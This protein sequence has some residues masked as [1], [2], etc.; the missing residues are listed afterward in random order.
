MTSPPSA[1]GRRRP[2]SRIGRA[3]EGHP[4]VMAPHHRKA[5]PHSAVGVL[6]PRHPGGSSWGS[7]EPCCWQLEGEDDADTTV[8]YIPKGIC[9]V[10]SLLVGASKKELS[11]HGKITTRAVP[12]IQKK[13]DCL[14][15]YEKL[16]I[17]DRQT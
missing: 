3:P 2:V 12:N 17:C 10:L 4:D 5:L 8:I 15:V 9:C 14:E 13:S 16:R 11:A 6:Q 1:V 7:A